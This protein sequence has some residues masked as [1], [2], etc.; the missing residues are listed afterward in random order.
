M[1]TPAEKMTPAE[2]A[3]ALEKRFAETQ[4]ASDLKEDDPLRVKADLLGDGFSQ[5]VEFLRS[6]LPNPAI[7]KMAAVLWDVVGNKIVPVALGPEVTAVSFFASKRGP[8]VNAYLILPP[9]WGEMYH[10]D[11]IMQ[12]EAIVFNGSKAVDVYN[13]RLDNLMPQRATMYEAEYL[14]TIQTIAPLYE[15]DEYQKGVLA[16]FPEGVDSPGAKGLLYESK[17]FRG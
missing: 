10:K 13:D 2:L 3:A 9:D 1:T 11:P 5:V 6:M 15:L 7:N 17:L 16:Q 14:K 12:T 4:F 8:I